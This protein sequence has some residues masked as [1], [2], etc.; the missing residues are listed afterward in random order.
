MCVEMV[1]FTERDMQCLFI[2]SSME[3]VNTLYLCTL[4]SMY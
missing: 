4:V 2:K 1:Q 3:Y